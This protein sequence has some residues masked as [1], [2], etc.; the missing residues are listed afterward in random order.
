MDYLIVAVTFV[1]FMVEAMLHYLI[2]HNSGKSTFSFKLPSLMDFGK[3]ILVV[4]TFSFV[5]GV[6]ISKLENR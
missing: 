4:G 3:I 1:V 2:G 5:N 6:I